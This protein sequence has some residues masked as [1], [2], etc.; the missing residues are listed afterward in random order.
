M[1]TC[2]FFSAPQSPLMQAYWERKLGQG[3]DGWEASA[4][5]HGT[6]SSLSSPYTP[7]RNRKDRTPDPFSI[8]HTQLEPCTQEWYL[9]MIVACRSLGQKHSYCKIFWF[10]RSFPRKQTCHNLSLHIGLG[11]IVL[12]GG[13]P[14]MSGSWCS[15][16]RGISG[17][18]PR[19]FLKLMGLGE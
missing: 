16:G 15:M 10:S 18:M 8:I 3:W 19:I 9:I 12:T 7:L 4:F 5:V 17:A 13:L 6:S 2:T 1:I 11:R 14:G